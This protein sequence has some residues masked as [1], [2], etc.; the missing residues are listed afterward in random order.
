MVLLYLKDEKNEKTESE[1]RVECCMWSVRGIKFD[2]ST[3]PF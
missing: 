1:W 2:L 3:C